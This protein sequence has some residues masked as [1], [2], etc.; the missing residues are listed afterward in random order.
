MNT[1]SKTGCMSIK[2]W[3]PNALTLGNLACGVISI[4]LVLTQG[5]QAAGWTVAVLMLVAM[6]CDFLDG[7]VARALRVSSPLGKELDSLADMV[8]FGLLPGMLALVMIQGGLA[9]MAS[10]RP[11]D[12]VAAWMPYLPYVALVIPLLSALRLAKFNIDTR[13]TDKF[14]GLATP[15]NA[16][17]FL[18]LFLVHAY[19]QPNAYLT[20]PLGPH[21]QLS[22]AQHWSWDWVGWMVHPYVVPVV[23]MVFGALLVTEI[24]LIAFKFKGMAWTSNWPKYLLL[25]ICVALLAIFTYRAGPLILLAYFLLSFIDAKRKHA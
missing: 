1:F 23:A 4:Q 7:F 11:S 24:P 6:L 12:E 25:G 19:D 15:A 3:I 14:L 22:S 17:F 8:T 10:A 20:T 2:T 13:Q 9:R 16:L 5:A 21:W 18:S